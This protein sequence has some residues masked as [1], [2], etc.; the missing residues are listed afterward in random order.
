MADFQEY[1]N[2]V[3]RNHQNS[4]QAVFNINIPI[5]DTPISVHP[6]SILSQIKITE[7]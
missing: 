1:V 4:K 5:L 6:N 3:T 7:N 2:Q